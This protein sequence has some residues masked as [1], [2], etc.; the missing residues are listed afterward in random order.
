MTTLTRP[1]RKN[2]LNYRQILKAVRD[3]SPQEQ[4]RLRDELTKS[5]G[6]SIV[7]PIG[8]V[9]ALQRGQEL[10]QAVRAELAG[11]ISGSL[12]DAMQSLRGRSWSS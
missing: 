7:P 11:Q 2:K 10:A 6:V 4:Q 8:S 9:A 3:L 5:A 12:E 1:P